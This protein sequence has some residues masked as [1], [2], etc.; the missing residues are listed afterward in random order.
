[1]RT[2]IAVEVSNEQVID[3]ILKFQ[4]GLK[5]N[6]KPVESHNLHFTLEF[7]GEISET[8]YE[9]IKHALEKIEFSRFL[10]KFTGIGV[11][12]KPTFP[13]VIWV[14]TDNTGGAALISLAKKI[15]DALLTLGFKSDKPFRPHITVFRIKNRIGDITKDLKE[16]AHLDFGSQQIMSFKFKQSTLTPRGP[17]YSD[18]L[19]VKAR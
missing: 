2:F 18:L 11:F 3:E 14:G 4:S 19:E 6:A 16:Y 10:V 7:L 1:M 12:P 17:I 13:R 9:K 8:Q 5:I 15:E